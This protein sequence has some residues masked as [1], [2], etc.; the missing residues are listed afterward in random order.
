MNVVLEIL[1]HP[2]G[3]CEGTLERFGLESA[4]MWSSLCWRYRG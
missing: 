1:Y 4:M 2:V 3:M